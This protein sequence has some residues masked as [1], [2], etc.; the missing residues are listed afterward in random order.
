MES[1]KRRHRRQK[2]AAEIKKE[3]EELRVELER[4]EQEELLKIGRGM[5]QVTGFETWEDIQTYLKE[6]DEYLKRKAGVA[7]QVTANLS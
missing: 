1:V 2:T 5:Q 4:R 6:K 7:E 3:I